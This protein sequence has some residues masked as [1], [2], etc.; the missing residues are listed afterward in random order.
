MKS[1]KLRNRKTDHLELCATKEVGFR[2]KSTLLEEVQLV[3]QSLPELSLEELDLSVELLGKRL[4]APLIIAAM[5][6][7]TRRAGKI[8]S[9][10]ALIAESRGYGLGLGSQRPMLQEPSKAASFQVRDQAPTA[11]I[12]GNIG[13]AQAR[14]CPS[15]T[16][17]SLVEQIG[18]DAL[19]VHMNPAMELIQPEGD[20]DFRG[21][22]DTFARLVSDLSVPVVAK[23]TGSGLSPQSVEKLQR[24]GVEVVDVSGAGGTSWVGVEA[25]RAQT[26]ESRQL[27]ELLWDWGVPTA[28]SVVNAVNARMTVIATGG[29]R[30][31]LDAACALAL[32]AG[33]VGIARP[34]L[35][36]YARGGRGS[37]EAYLVQVQHELEA[38]MLLCGVR[39]VA[40]LRRAPR[41]ITGKLLEWLSSE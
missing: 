11:L 14:E 7:G 32:G 3:H 9:D 20:C 31:G 2:Q 16:L 37:A 29:I 25:L 34:V 30:T 23:E 13:V 38:V 22:V 35:Q 17:A 6:G 15:R 24:A 27:G 19:C 33:A 5:T 26:D 28:V 21:C 1:K 18:A 4:R 41:V 36:A 39:T 40:E 8:N 10:L 12:L